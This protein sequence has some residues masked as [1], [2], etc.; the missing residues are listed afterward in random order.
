MK[1][2][3][4]LTEISFLMEIFLLAKNKKILILANRIDMMSVYY[5]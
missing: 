2:R 5:Q 4:L 1:K 3:Y